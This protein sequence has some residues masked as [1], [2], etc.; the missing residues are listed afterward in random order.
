MR[1]EPLG[2]QQGVGQVKQ[3]ACGD[4][5]GERIIED[6]DPVSSKPFAGIGYAYS[7]HDKTGG[8]GPGMT[9]SLHEVLP[10]PQLEGREQKP[11]IASV[12]C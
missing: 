6:H 9:M 10:M 12:G 8:R 11:V 4:E 2:P 7:R 5:A 3:Q 1:S